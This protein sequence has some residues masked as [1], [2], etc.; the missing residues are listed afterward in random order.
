MAD[1]RVAHGEREAR[2]G[3]KGIAPVGHGRRAGVRRLAAEDHAVALD[4]D[5][6]EHG[7]DGHAEAL[8]HRPLLDVQLEI[9]AHVA[10]PALGCRRAVELDAV[11]ADDVLEALAVGVAQVAH[12]VGVE[13]AG[14]GGGAEEAAA[15]ARALLVGPVHERDR[16]GR[17]ALSRDRAQRLESGH[18]AER[19]I[20]PAAVRHRV[21]VRADHDG[22]GALPCE[23]R[24]EVARL[25]DLDLHRQLCERLAQHAPRVLPL[26]R[27]A[28]PSRTAGAAGQ[29]GE[30]TQIGDR[31]LRLTRDLH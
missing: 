16:A 25:V 20:Q 27:P 30:R 5:R 31:A 28:Q 21:D 1:R 12:R 24:P 8:E 3:E 15:E 23:S 7:S 19:P 26:V 18:D 4:A 13:R 17:R 6:A 22:L 2:R 10:Q 29:L 14:H 11:L 9:G